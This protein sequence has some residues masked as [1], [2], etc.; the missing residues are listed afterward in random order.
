MMPPE[1]R[2]K[3]RKAIGGGG[4]WRMGKETDAFLKGAKTMEAAILTVDD[5][6]KSLRDSIWNCAFMAIGLKIEGRT[7]EHENAAL[8]AQN[9]AIFGANARL[10]EV[11]EVN[12]WIAAIHE[13]EGA[14]SLAEVTM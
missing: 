1:S 7:T 2:R 12:E 4:L 5:V 11:D 14:M 9:F 10:L 6:R 3:R 8:Q 13:R